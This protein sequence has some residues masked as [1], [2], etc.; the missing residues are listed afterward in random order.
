M[1]NYNDYPKQRINPDDDKNAQLVCMFCKRP[2]SE[3]NGRLEG[4]AP[5]CKYRLKKQGS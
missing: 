2:E 3:I 5:D 4:H 1:A